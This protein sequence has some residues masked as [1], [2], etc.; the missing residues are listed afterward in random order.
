[1]HRLRFR[2]RHRLR[3]LPR[4]QRGVGVLAGSDWACTSDEDLA[5]GAASGSQDAYSELV[6]RHSKKLLNLAWRMTGSQEAALD[7]VQEAWL[8]GWKGIRS[9]R[10]E[11]QF[12]SWMRRILVNGI[13]NE[14]RKRSRRAALVSLDRSM[15]SEESGEPLQVEDEGADPQDIVGRA[16]TA[17][18]IG[19]AVVRLPDMYRVVF[20]LRETELMSYSEI[21]DVL[22]IAEGTVKSRLNM[23]RRMLRETLSEEVGSARFA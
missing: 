8:S 21:A 6:R 5:R 17:R 14:F 12:Y 18:E 23:A 4:G 16:E 10:G 15:D 7:A 2:S 22:G 19:Q 11:A 9:F 13:N 3:D 1:M 20:L